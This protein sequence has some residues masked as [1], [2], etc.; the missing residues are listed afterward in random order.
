MSGI[1]FFI[2]ASCHPL[3]NDVHESTGEFVDILSSHSLYASIVKQ[4]IVMEVTT[5]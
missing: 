2:F 3:N 5:S 4:S 1:L